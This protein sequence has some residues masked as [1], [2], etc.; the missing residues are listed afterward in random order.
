MVVDRLHDGSSIT[1]TALSLLMKLFNGLSNIAQVIFI[2]GNHDCNLNNPTEIDLLSEIT[3]N[4]K[5]DNIYY[6]KNS[7]TYCYRNILFGVTS[8]Y[9]NDI[10][11]INKKQKHKYHIGLCHRTFYNEKMPK[12]FNNYDYV[13]L[14]DTHKYI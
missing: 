12:E 8:I 6:L 3:N 5:L 9:D 13:L 2:A 1:S 10:Y 11:V 14:G 7:G 4:W